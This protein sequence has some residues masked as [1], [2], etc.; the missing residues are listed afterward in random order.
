MNYG[1]TRTLFI[2]S[3]LFSISL[4][5]E[6]DTVHEI[7]QERSDTEE[8][9]EILDMPPPS[10]EQSAEEISLGSVFDQYPPVFYP[11]STHWLVA[12]SAVGDSIELED[13][14]V[15]K[16]SNYDVY[17]SLNWKSND[18]LMITQNHSWFSKYDYRIINQATGAYLETKLFLGPIKNGAYTRYIIDIDVNR[19]LIKLSDNTHWELNSWD[20]YVYTKWLIGD[21]VILGYNSGWEAEYEAILINVNMNKY[22]RAKQY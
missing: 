18:P 4:F 19:N 3:S 12:V 7:V 22:V 13:G 15:W 20:K 14:S 2:F 8:K 21:A 16:I 11:S 5:A 17:K 1:F 9:S 6:T 10:I